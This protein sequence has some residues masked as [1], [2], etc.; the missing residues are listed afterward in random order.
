MQFQV[1]QF[2]ETE[3]KVVGP[4]TIRQFIYIAIGGTISFL[5]YFT[6]ATWLWAIFSIVV[7]SGAIALAFVKVE[8]RPLVQIALSAFNFYWKPQTYVWQSE[9]PAEVKSE[10]VAR[11]EAP[12][13]I[14]LENIVAGMALRDAWR[15]VQTGEK[16]KSMIS[17]QQFFG[18]VQE[19]YNMY[20]DLGGARQAARRIDYR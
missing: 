4:F 20:R 5:F 6:V 11:G 3:D 1:P 13:G 12:S 18:K 17:N 2:I 16:T 7:L 10:A 19:R 9:R 14:S 8:G 15:D